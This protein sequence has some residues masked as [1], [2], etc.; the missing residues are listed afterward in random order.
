MDRFVTLFNQASTR[1]ITPCYMFLLMLS[2]PLSSTGKNIFLVLATLA[3]LLTADYR[4]LLPVVCKKSWFQAAILMLLMVLVGCLWSPATL[5]EQLYVI[6]KY[7]KLLYFPFL[8]IGF[9]SPWV[10]RYCLHAF[11]LAMLFTCFISLLKFLGYFQSYQFFVDAVF[12]NHIVTSFMVAFAAYVCL[13]IASSKTNKLVRSMYI[14]LALLFT[15][16]IFVINYSR[17]GYLIY[18]F[19][20]LLL[21]F[22]LCTRRQAIVALLLISSIFT[23]SY[24][25]IPTVTKGIQSISSE[26]LDYQHNNKETSLGL[27][28]QFHDFA[29]S[30]FL[31]HPLRGNGTASFA[32]YFGIDNPVPSWGHG[33]W[34]PHS[35]YWLI[36]C[37]FGLVGVM[38]QFYFFYTLLIASWRLKSMRVLALGVLLPFF[39]G[40]MTESLLFYSGSGYFFI[41]FMALCFGEQLEREE[42]LKQGL[43]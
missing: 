13:W 34:E 15:L 42:P 33:L 32:Y 39:I 6:G 22:Q 16:H 29:H 27:R 43:S 38:I 35:Q 9:K 8:V 5:H 18:V 26:F 30:L 21:T 10:R 41:V 23:A 31:H 17:T 2:V 14:L 1:F 24:V 19:L 4:H 12:Q 11:I 3:V 40:N 36:A 7:A 28:L 25:F 20:M 37:E